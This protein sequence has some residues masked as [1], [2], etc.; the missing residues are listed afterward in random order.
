MLCLDIF[1]VIEYLRSVV[2]LEAHE[3]RLIIFILKQLHHWLVIS[4]FHPYF[5]LY[6]LSDMSCA[7]YH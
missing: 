1:E 5:A 3:M 6:E 4:M 2:D 7:V